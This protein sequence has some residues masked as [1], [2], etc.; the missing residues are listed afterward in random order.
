MGWAQ[1]PPYFFAYTET[2]AYLA[3]ATSHPLP[4]HPILVSSQL[5]AYQQQEHQFHPDAILLGVDTQPPL[6]YTDIYIDDFLIAAQRPLQ[7]KMLNNL[8]HAIESVFHDPPHSNRKAVNSTKK[9]Q[10]GDVTWSMRK[11]NFGMGR[12]YLRHVTTT[13]QA[14]PAKHG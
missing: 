10:Q 11:K 4:P 12:G 3:N 2:V 8:L 14:S 1:S 6:S 9:L 13:A 5:P 7:H